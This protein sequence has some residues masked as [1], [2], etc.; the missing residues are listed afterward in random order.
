MTPEVFRMSATA[1]AIVAA[2][3][4][5]IPLNRCYLKSRPHASSRGKRPASGLLAL[6]SRPLGLVRGRRV[7]EAYSRDLEHMAEAIAASLDAGQS[8]LQAL[9][10]ASGSARG[11]L[12][13]QIKT[14]LAQ[15]GAG[16]PLSQAL[17]AMAQR[18][19]SPEVTH[20]VEALAVCETQGGSLRDLLTALG[21]VVRERREWAREVQAKA[22]EARWSAVFLASMPPLMGGYLFLSH[23]EMMRPMLADSM[24]RAVLAY[25]VV[26]WVAGV[27]VVGRLVTGDPEA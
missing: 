24:G 2:Y 8:L 25:A 4:T 1:V 14:A 20:F 19:K 22:G 7:R 13:R 27:I 23:A 21:E 11:P 6:A 15:Y 5:I 10:S 16:I 3:L 9:E 12:G 17:E 26:S 18:I